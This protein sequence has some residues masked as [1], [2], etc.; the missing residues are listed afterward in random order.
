[1]SV[2]IDCRGLSCPVP[3]LETAK[4]LR[5]L[6]P[7][8]EILVLAD[9]PGVERDFPAFCRANRHELL[10]L[11]RDGALFRTRIRKRR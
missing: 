4:A 6:P 8:A 1:V 5:P 2:E 11:D 9:D 3:V 10:G 7:G